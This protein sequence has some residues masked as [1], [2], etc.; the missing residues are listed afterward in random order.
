[1][2]GARIRLY[3]LPLG[4]GG[5][6]V[7][8]NGRVYEA[9]TARRDHRAP[10]DLYHVALEVRVAEARYAIEMGPAWGGL[11]GDRGV[12]AS[13][14]VGLR[15]LG[16]SPLFRYEVRRW[17]DGVLP[18]ADAAVGGPV[19]VPT[20]PDRCVRL[21]ALTPLVP[22]LTWGRDELHLGEMWNSNSL[23]AW[24]LAGSGHDPEALAPPPGGRAPGW[25]AGLRLART[26]DSVAA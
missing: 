23:V 1:M 26:W 7:A 10:A 24:L 2:D 21:L 8:R 22:T 12:V 9:W 20:D 6:V 15:W 17:R 14:P 18:D 13:G 25:D 3:W 19:S 5:H 4:A 11:P 16:F